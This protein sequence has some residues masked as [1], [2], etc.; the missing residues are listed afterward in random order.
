[1]SRR[2]RDKIPRT[3]TIDRRVDEAL[4]G[5]KNAS[6]VVND[7]LVENMSQIGMASDQDRRTVL[8]AR[9]RK[10]LKALLPE[11]IKDIVNDEIER[12][13]PEEMEEDHDED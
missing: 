11:A 2:S 7:I 4:A 13:I 5:C 9:L 1:M 10:D 3:F 12:L 6:E 8:M